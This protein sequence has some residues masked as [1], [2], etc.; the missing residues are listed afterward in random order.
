VTIP[1]PNDDPRRR[2][3]KVRDWPEG[4]RR[5]W[6]KALEPGDIL[7]GSVGPGFHWSGQTREK[8]RK[9]YGRWLTFLTVTGRFEPDASPA[10][11]ITPENV[12]AYI[13]ELRETVS[14]WTL[15]GRLAELLA[16]AKALSPDRDWG[17][18]RQVVRHFEGRV[19]SSKDKLARLRSAAE[20]AKWAFGRM[21]AL[22]SGDTGRRTPVHFRDAL[23]VALLIHCPT[24]RLGNLAMIRSS[25]SRP[26]RRKL[27]SLLPYLFRHRLCLILIAIS[28]I[29]AQ[30]FWGVMTRIVSGSTMLGGP[31]RKEACMRVLSR[32]PN[33]L[34]A[35]RS[36][37]TCSG[38]VP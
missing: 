22:T 27:E 7:D 17:W 23:M 10:D 8:Y 29:I 21:D 33:G 25:S 18:L 12:R 30:P 3:L 34:S 11:R 31:F 1:H 16:A 32:S 35:L 9:G 36:I 2:C 19:Q 14:S 4:D 5:A 37:R 6:M 13:E 20:I 24:M 15:W 26:R 28:V 38:I